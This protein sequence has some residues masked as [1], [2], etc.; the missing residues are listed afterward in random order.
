MCDPHARIHPPTPSCQWIEIRF[1]H[2]YNTRIHSRRRPGPVRSR[3]RP[4]SSSPLCVFCLLH[5]IATPSHPGHGS[6]LQAQM[7]GAIRCR[8]PARLV[9]PEWTNC[10]LAGYVT[11]GPK[12]NK[13][14]LLGRPSYLVASSTTLPRSCSN[15]QNPVQVPPGIACLNEVLFNSGIRRL[16]VVSN[17]DPRGQSQDKIPWKGYSLQQ[18]CFRGIMI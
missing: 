14:T 18:L 6:S 5:P 13:I 1:V 16:Q 11:E 3:F 17:Q 2:D 4:I 8:R 10:R 12:R 7:R 9:E 15:S